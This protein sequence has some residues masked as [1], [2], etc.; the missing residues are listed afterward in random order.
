MIYKRAIK[1]PKTVHDKIIQYNTQD[2][3]NATMLSL[4][5]VASDNNYKNK[6]LK[7]KAKY[8]ALKKQLN[9]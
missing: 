2:G 7:Y 8:L 3:F 4:G 6:Y 1:E 9:L 5:S